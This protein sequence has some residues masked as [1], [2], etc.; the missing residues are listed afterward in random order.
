MSITEQIKKA[1]N[2]RS[3]HGAVAAVL[4]VLLAGFATRMID[5]IFASPVLSDE[6]IIVYLITMAL[7]TAWY[8]VLRLMDFLFLW[9]EKSL[10][11]KVAEDDV[12]IP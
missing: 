9:I 1:I 7:F 2:A 4:T 6:D 10:D 5:K 12:L 11:T 3:L 8:V